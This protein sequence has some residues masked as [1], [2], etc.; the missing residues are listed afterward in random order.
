MR[1]GKGGLGEKLFENS[2]A[3]KNVQSELT[4]DAEL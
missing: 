1:R 3:A 4:S 2:L